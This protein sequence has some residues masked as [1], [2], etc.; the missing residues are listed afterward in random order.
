M[1]LMAVVVECC[2]PCNRD[3][4]RYNTCISNDVDDDA[5]LEKRRMLQ[6]ETFFKP[7]KCFASNMI[8]LGL[9][10]TDAHVLYYFQTI[11]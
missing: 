3:E 9:M 4:F 6:K 11:F 8:L 2:A 1:V 7:N 5:E 10:Y